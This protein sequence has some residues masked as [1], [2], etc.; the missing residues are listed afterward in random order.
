MYKQ[1][2]YFFWGGGGGGWYFK[3]LKSKN[4]FIGGLRV[5]NTGYI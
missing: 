4:F 1:K 3:I 2:I 5:M